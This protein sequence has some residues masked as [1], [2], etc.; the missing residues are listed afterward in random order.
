MIAERPQTEPVGLKPTS[1]YLKETFGKIST[2]FRLCVCMHYE[3]KF[4]SSSKYL[5]TCECTIKFN[6]FVHNKQSYKVK[7]I[8][9]SISTKSCSF[10]AEATPKLQQGDAH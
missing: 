10:L 1:S 4:Y 8:N 9:A 7:R 3:V 2:D 6:Y 5:G